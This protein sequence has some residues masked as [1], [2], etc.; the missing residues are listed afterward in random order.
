[1]SRRKGETGQCD[2][3]RYRGNSLIR[4]R[5]PPWTTMGPYA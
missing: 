4:N 5:H 1:M 2:R 3:S